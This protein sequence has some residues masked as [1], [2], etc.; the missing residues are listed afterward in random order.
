LQI[1][2]AICHPSLS[3]DAQAGLALRTLCGFGINEIADAFL[4]STDTINKR[5]YRAREKLR[6]QKIAI[7]MPAA[8]DI[9]S[10]LEG[11]LTT[12]YLLF[13]E[14]YYSES[15]SS[16]L[17]QELCAE[18]MRLAQQLLHNL[19]TNVPAVNAL[20]A[21]MCFHS[22]RFAARQNR[23]DMVLYADQDESLWDRQ[24]I[25]Q[26]IYYL[27]IA[28]TGQTLT[29]Y[30]LEA[31]IAYWHTVKEDTTEKWQHILNLYETLMQVAYSP[32]AA[33]NS[34]YA[35]SKIKGKEVAIA[36]AEKLNLDTNHYYHTLLG[37]L[38]T[39]IDNDKA[40]CHFTKAHM[41][42]KSAA[43]KQIIAKHLSQLVST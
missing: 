13:N 31:A 30:H 5:L 21:L 43:D 3:P 17:R 15:G 32:V 25:R 20:Y 22:S 9:N 40:R 34:L 38:Y 27:H 37:M 14:G 23:G 11:V 8:G 10:R 7:E 28:S 33:L 29:R 26:G 39:G 24:L 4:T 42:A 1:L 19:S 6:E 16:F 12:L 2:F 35:L 18:A 41:L 36:A